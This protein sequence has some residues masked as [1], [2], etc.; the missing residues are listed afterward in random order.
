MSSQ[1]GQPFNEAIRVKS[2]NRK[3][4]SIFP[5]FSMPC[6]SAVRPAAIVGQYPISFVGL[7]TNPNRRSYAS[8]ISRTGGAAVSTFSS[9]SRGILVP[10]AKASTMLGHCDLREVGSGQAGK[11]V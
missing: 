11:K 9:G 8:I 2:R 3:R 4:A 1:N 5:A 7:S 6:V 10:R